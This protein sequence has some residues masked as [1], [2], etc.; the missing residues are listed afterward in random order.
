MYKKG[1]FLQSLEIIKKAILH[2]GDKRA[3]ILEHY[4][5]ILYKLN[6]K[7]KALEFWKKAMEKGKGS[8]F[9]EKK[10]KMKKL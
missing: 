4:G 6:E 2:G 9:L 10:I 8:E 7:T 3:V 1:E 5:D